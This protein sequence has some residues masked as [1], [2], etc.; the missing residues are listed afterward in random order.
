MLRKTKKAFTKRT[1]NK[2]KEFEK[3]KKAVKNHIIN[4][5]EAKNLSAY[6]VDLVLEIY[7]AQIN[8]AKK[9][10][11]PCIVATIASVSASGMSR[12]VKFGFV[13]KN[14]EF[15]DITYLFAEL[16]GAKVRSSYSSFLVKGCG[17]DMIFAV[18]HNIFYTLTPR[19]EW[20]K[21]DDF[22]RYERF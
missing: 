13:R 19:S 16:Y 8:A 17:M 7:N 3:M 6:W 9:H 12:R 20:S 1:H 2:K 18:L 22:C 5:C 10:T 4:V 15:V 21:H 11:H 14:G